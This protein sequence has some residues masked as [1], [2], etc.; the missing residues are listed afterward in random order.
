MNS[1]MCIKMLRCMS[2]SIIIKFIRYVRI[3]K[4]R[5]EPKLDSSTHLQS[6]E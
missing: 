4:V 1:L 2:V 3:S 6:F 5:Y